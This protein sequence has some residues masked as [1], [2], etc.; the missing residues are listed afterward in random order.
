[1]VNRI[2][3]HIFGNGIVRSVDNFG[4]IGEKPSHPELLDHLANQFVQ[5]GWS[6]KR[7]IRMMA[8]SETF[9]Q[10]GEITARARELDPQ[11]A[12]LHHYPLRRLAAE[13]IRDSILNS[14]G[15]LKPSI[16]GPSVHPHRDQPQD[17]RKLFSGP[18]DGEG[19]RSIYLKVTRMEGTRLL[20]T[21]DYPAPMVAR[22]SRDV[23]NVPAQ[24]LTLLNDPFVIAEAERCAALLL[25]TKGGSVDARVEQLF[26][27]AL[28]RHP[29]PAERERFRGL[30][31]ELASLH[32]VPKEALLT[33]A[34][35]WK[36]LAHTVFNMKE[37]IYVQ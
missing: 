13:S 1:M 4:I 8:L 6:L 5:Q 31:A 25:K 27:T 29:T 14:S 11:N 30:A 15:N 9:Q 19:R 17:Y 20:E 28:G 18:L 33:N 23:T 22:G 16:F 36:D 37:F 12:L 2:W 7:M 32:Q 10:S 34:V 3:H 26:A 24:A 35:V 21:F